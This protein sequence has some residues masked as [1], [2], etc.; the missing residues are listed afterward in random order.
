V[1]LLLAARRPVLGRTRLTRLRALAS[2]RTYPSAAFSTSILALFQRLNL[3]HWSQPSLTDQNIKIA[4]V[5]GA[6]TNAVFFV[7]FEPSQSTP[8]SEAP[9][10]VRLS[11]LSV[12]VLCAF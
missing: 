11:E 6:M 4:K 9:T 1:R 5:S 2:D 7:S 12:S 10:M 3:P 8:T